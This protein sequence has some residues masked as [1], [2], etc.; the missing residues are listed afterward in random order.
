MRRSR[1]ASQELDHH[2]LPR[3]RLRLLSSHDHCGLRYA[4]KGC[5]CADG[6]LEEPE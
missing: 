6:S 3:L 1:Q 4:V 2:G 5:Y